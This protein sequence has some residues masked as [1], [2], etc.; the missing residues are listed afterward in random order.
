MCFPNLIAVMI[1]GKKLYIL[2]H[3]LLMTVPPLYYQTLASDR[4][5]PNED[6]VLMI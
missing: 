1:I 3:Q 2:A 4:E 6:N 5:S